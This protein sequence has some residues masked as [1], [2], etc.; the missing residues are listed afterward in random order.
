MHSQLRAQKNKEETTDYCPLDLFSG[1]KSRILKAIHSLW[2]AWVASNATVNN[3]KIFARGQF[4]TPS[5]V[6]T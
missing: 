6:S 1:D 3:L 2:D 5:E 4:V